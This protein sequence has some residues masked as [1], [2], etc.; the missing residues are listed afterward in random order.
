[1][2]GGLGH[3]GLFGPLCLFC[4]KGEKRGSAATL[5]GSWSRLPSPP[6][7][8]PGLSLDGEKKLKCFG[9][10]GLKRRGSLI[11]QPLALF[12]FRS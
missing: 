1:M 3:G 12:P 5:G 8:F 7:L 6:S 2:G 10:G 4:P 9:D 11:A